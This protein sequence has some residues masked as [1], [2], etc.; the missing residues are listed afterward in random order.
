[1]RS[2]HSLNIFEEVISRNVRHSN[3][4]RFCEEDADDAW[5]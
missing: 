1:M 3:V 4:G 2:R 5:Q